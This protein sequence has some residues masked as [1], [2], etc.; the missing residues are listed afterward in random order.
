MRDR[1]T[2]AS[3]RATLGEASAPRVAEVAAALEE[4]CA[5]VDVTARP[6]FAALRAQPPL[7]DP[8]GRLWRAADLVREHRG[9]AHLGAVVAAGL[10]PVRAGILAELW[11]GYPVGEYSATRGWPSERADAALARLESDGLVAAGALTSAGRTLRDEIEAATDRSQEDLLAALPD[12]GSVIGS[13]DAW[14]ATCIEAGTFP[15]D[16]R[17]RAAG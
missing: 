5:V 9:D 2:A 3:L 10:D 14:S 7:A 17:K 12:V 8:F 13:L 16:P 1:A 11:V 6:L 15:D 4:A